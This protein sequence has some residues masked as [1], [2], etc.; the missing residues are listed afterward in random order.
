MSSFSLFRYLLDFLFWS[1]FPI[2]V[3]TQRVEVLHNLASS[4]VYELAKQTKEAHSSRIESWMCPLDPTL[5]SYNQAWTSI[6]LYFDRG[7][8]IAKCPKIH[9]SFPP[10]LRLH[11]SFRYTQRLHG[12]VKTA[13]R[14]R[15]ACAYPNHLSLSTAARMQQRVFSPKTKHAYTLLPRGEQESCL[16]PSPSKKYRFSPTVLSQSGPRTQDSASSLPADSVHLHVLGEARHR[17]AS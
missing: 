12:R 17:D 15:L 14:N 8:S 16:P 5:Q 9:V 10:I 13:C 4:G 7:P 2:Y 3:W 1:R 11:A 6:W